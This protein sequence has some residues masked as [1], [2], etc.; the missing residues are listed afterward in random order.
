MRN[1]MARLGSAAA[2]VAILALSSIAHAAGPSNVRLSKAS[3]QVLINRGHGFQPATAGMVLRPGDR[4]LVVGGG[5]ASVSYSG[6]CGMLL[7][8]GSMATI[9]TLDPCRSGARAA[10]V[11]TPKLS[12]SSNDLP[13][14][15]PIKILQGIGGGGQSHSP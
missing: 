15:P 11:I 5:Q 9:S 12:A 8:T 13:P 14:I 2:A 1:S 10:G 4:V 3:G 6:G 7:P